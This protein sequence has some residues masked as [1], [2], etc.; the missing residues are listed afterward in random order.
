M[1]HEKNHNTPVSQI[2]VKFASLFFIYNLP[3]YNSDIRSLTWVKQHLYYKSLDHFPEPG[4]WELFVSNI[5]KF[6]SNIFD[7]IS[8]W[9]YMCLVCIYLLEI[10]SGDDHWVTVYNQIYSFPKVIGSLEILELINIF[11]IVLLQGKF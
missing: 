11:I 4:H 1:C 7:M 6:Q 2:W 8:I 3:F 9:K 10:A 5:P